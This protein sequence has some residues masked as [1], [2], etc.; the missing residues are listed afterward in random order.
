MRVSAAAL[1]I[2][3]VTSF[4]GA[5]AAHTVQRS[6]TGGQKL[7]PGPAAIAGQ[8]MENDAPVGRARVILSSAA[9]PL[10]RVTL[11]DAQGR[12]E[13]SGIPAGDYDMLVMR[14]GYALTAAGPGCRCRSG[15]ANADRPDAAAA[16]RRHD[17]GPNPRR[18][19]SPSPARRSR[20]CRCARP[21][22]RSR[23][24]R[25][26]RLHRRSW[27]VQAH[28][29]VAGQYF[30]SRARGLR[31]AGDETA[32]CAIPRPISGGRD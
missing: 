15:A 13:F 28:R 32:R 1:A 22:A 23:C 12:Y 5:P 25:R 31:R 29:T 16:A 3:F 2:A 4:S 17:S 18:R 19:R 30:S 20:R 21:K 6:Q 14:S 9:L 8:V 26:G 24:S 11:T 10:Q 7:P 27:R